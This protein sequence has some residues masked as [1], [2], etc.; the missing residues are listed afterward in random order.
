MR[1]ISDEEDSE[2]SEGG[3]GPSREFEDRDAIAKEIFAGDEE[4]G[5]LSPHAAVSSRARNDIIRMVTFEGGN[6]TECSYRGV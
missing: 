3:A 4:E 1:Q 5:E 2:D 6:I